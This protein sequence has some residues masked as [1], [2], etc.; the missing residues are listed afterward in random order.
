VVQ[1]NTIAEV[2]NDQIIE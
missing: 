1:T 2:Q